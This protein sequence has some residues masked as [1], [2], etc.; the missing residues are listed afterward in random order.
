[1]EEDLAKLLS[2]V[3]DIEAQDKHFIDKN[4]AKPVVSG[5]EKDTYAES[6]QLRAEKKKR[7][8]RGDQASKTVFRGDV[9]KIWTDPTLAEWPENDYRILV[10]NLPLS[11]TE[12]DLIDA[13]KHL[14]SLA[15]VKIVR[16]SSGRNRTYGFVS[17]LDVNDY[18]TA[19]KTLTRTFVGKK[20]VVLEASKWKDRNIKLPNT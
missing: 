14:K 12:Q 2:I 9:D 8:H 13:F 7:V 3:G 4:S 5:K 17:L 6:I 1:M 18:I 19:M 11:A 16:D 20:R 15:K 10:R